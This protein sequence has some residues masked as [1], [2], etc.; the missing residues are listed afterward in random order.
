LDSAKDSNFDLTAVDKEANTLNDLEKENY[1]VKTI[2]E[3]LSNTDRLKNLLEPFDLVVCVVPGY[4]GFQ[5][6]KAVIEANK[7]RCY[8]VIHQLR[9][10]V[11]RT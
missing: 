2:Q 3:D 6:L 8:S 4:I 9:R 1:P 7:I 11:L 5:T 10:D